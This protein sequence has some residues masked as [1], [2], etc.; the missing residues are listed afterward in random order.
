MTL[1]LQGIKV[2]EMGQL[3]AGPFAAK[4]L[5]ELVPTLARSSHL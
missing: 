5:A 1:P 3:I 4:M 2:I